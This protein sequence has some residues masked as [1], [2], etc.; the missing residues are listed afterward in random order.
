[1]TT[2]GTHL[3]AHL[4]EQ[5]LPEYPRPNLVRKSFINLNG[6]WDYA[7]TSSRALPSVYE[8]QIRVPFSPESVLSGVS[9][10]LQPSEF[11]VYR[12][13]I[14]LPLQFRKD[15]L[16]LHFGAIDQYATV[17]VDQQIVGNHLGGYTP[18]TLKINP[19]KDSFELVVVVQDDSNQFGHLTGKQRIQRGGIFYTPQSGIWQTV[20]M[21]SVT[22]D[23]IQKWRIIPDLDQ[24][25]FHFE[26]FKEGNDPVEIIATY[27]DQEVGRIAS[28][29]STATLPLNAV[30]PW[31]PDT[32]DL[33]HFT[34][35]SGHD[36]FTSY[37]GL[38]K[39]ERKVDAS[40]QMR[41]YLN[42]QPIFQSGV[43][44]QGYY[45]DGLLTPPSDEAMLGDIQLMKTMGFNMIRKHIKVE[46]LRW[47]YHCDQLGILVWQDM[48]SGTEWE[49][50]K[51]HHGLS[52]LHL[53]MPDMFRCFFG[54][55]RKSGRQEYEVCLHEMLETLHSYSCIVVWV[56]FNEAWGQFDTRRIT[57][58][59]HHYDPS[60]LIDHASGWS[61]QGVGDF[62]SRHIYFTDIK[63]SKRSGRRRINA[64]TEFGGYSY[65]ISGHRYNPD[66][67]F[68]YRHYADQST[69]ELAVQT[70]YRES[71]RPQIQNGLSALV[72][73]QLTDVE[74]EINGWM[75]YDR[76]MIK[77]TP[78][79]IATLNQELHDAF[80]NHI[81]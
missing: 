11:L 44:D 27:Q 1:M 56:P 48:V 61:D 34:V 70:L 68:G 26:W 52:I 8:G 3:L 7:I 33:Y 10:M 25:C 19:E 29:A 81:I 51:F 16:L 76:K 9:R 59:I 13:V 30:H 42:N 20:W 69:F 80:Q 55:Q 21:E 4:D 74:D 14:E 43:L 40:G 65:P 38:R 50:V 79:L 67:A 36:T 39:V 2:W 75:T 78:E 41:F 28:S 63:F 22:K 62:C 71:I 66:F 57:Q 15:I 35:V 45:S 58:K 32:P 17:Y 53:H 12:K 23:Y 54:R 47:Y 73:T 5:P 24:H 49:N 60:R 37:A 18:F 77:A 46:P 64:L 72:Y 6:W 31:S